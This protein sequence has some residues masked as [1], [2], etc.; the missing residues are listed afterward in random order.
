MEAFVFARFIAK[1]IN[2]WGG[3]SC[4][5]VRRKSGKSIKAYPICLQAAWSASILHPSNSEADKFREI[6]FRCVFKFVVYM[7]VDKKKKR[8][9]KTR[10]TVE[11]GVFIQ[12][13]SREWGENAQYSHRMLQAPWAE[14]Y[15]SF[16]AS[17]ISS[18]IR[19]WTPLLGAN[20]SREFDLTPDSQRAEEGK[21]RLL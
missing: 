12:F 21:S 2:Y 11:Q 18:T 15:A 20:R 8:R 4:E 13:S 3:V 9:R 17:M 1:H 10:I 5:I 16:T 19:K 14:L 7:L 6:S